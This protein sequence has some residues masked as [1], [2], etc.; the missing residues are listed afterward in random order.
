MAS[1]SIPS[2]WTR[3]KQF[4]DPVGAVEER[5]LA[6]R[7]EVNERHTAWGKISGLQRIVKSVSS[8][9][10]LRPMRPMR[11]IA[12]L[13]VLGLMMAVVHRVTAGGPLEA[14]ATLALGFL[15]LAAIVGGELARRARLPRLTG[16]LLIGFAVGP[17]WLGLVRREEVEALRF[18]GDCAVALIGLAAGS[19]LT[20]DALRQD[21]VALARVTSGA[22]GFPLCVVSA[23]SR[24]GGPVV[25]AH[26]ASAAR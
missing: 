22:I 16:Y 15:L 19:E 17:A 9:D 26:A 21:R 11:S 13:F 18:I 23:R 3:S 8:P 1:E 2:A 7:V 20:L 10:I 6:V 4:G 24:V 25:P 14:R 5:V 12:T